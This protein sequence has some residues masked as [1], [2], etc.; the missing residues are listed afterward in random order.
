MNL[1]KAVRHFLND[2]ISFYDDIDLRHLVIL[3][4][5][6]HV[7]KYQILIQI[8]IIKIQTILNGRTVKE[9]YWIK[10]YRILIARKIF[11]S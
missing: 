3:S 10:R 11:L 5:V 9:S 4:L 2:R 6:F 7:M 8:Y 1:N